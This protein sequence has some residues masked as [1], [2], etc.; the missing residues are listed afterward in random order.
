MQALPD[1]ARA[2]R[3]IGMRAAPVMHLEVRVGAVA[4]E[5]R[6][7][8][9]EIGESGDV[10]LGRRCGRPM[11]VDGGHVPF[12]CYIP[13]NNRTGSSRSSVR[14]RV[15]LTKEYAVAL[16]ADFDRSGLLRC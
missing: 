2:F 12:P 6:A 16:P 8:G 15:R 4:K 13:L 7:T 3:D 11:K 9:P 5:L 14:C 10:L 1:P